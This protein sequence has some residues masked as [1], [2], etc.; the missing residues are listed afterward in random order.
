MPTEHQVS[1]EWL[2]QHQPQPAADGG[3]H[4][5]SAS[6]DKKNPVVIF[7]EKEAPSAS[8]LWGLT[9]CHP[10]TSEETV[11]T[12]T[13]SI[14]TAATSSSRGKSM[15]TLKRLRQEDDEKR[16]RDS[17]RGKSMT[18]LKRLRET[19][20]PPEELSGKHLTALK[21]RGE[22]QQATEE[23][24]RKKQY[25]KTCFVNGCTKFVQRGGLCKRHGATV[26]MCSSD[27]CTNQVIKGGVCIRHGAKRKICSHEGCK[28]G[29]IKGGVCVRHGAKKY[30]YKCS[31]DGCTNHA[32]KEGVCMRHGAKLKRCNHEGCTNYAQKGGVCIRHGAKKKVKS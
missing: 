8:P 11:P 19:K 32:Q 5:F 13:S 10:T 27:G 22:Q 28:N 18:T 29:V 9:I 21:K 15:N 20:E 2:E 1:R 16:K 12:A 25:R 31:A 4:F 6:S 24:A 7:A 23:T 26:K 17:L 30:K 14:N 3:Y